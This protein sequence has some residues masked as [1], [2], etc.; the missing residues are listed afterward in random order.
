M[1]KPPDRPANQASRARPAAALRLL[2]RGPDGLADHELLALWLSLP[3]AARAAELL[4]RLGELDTQPAM[5]LLE[6][7]GLGPV[8]V[9]RLKAAAALLERWALS[10]LADQGPVLSCTTSVRAFLRGKLSR[11]TRE[12]FACLF[13]DSRHRLIRYEVLFM[14]TVD[15]AAVHPRE[16][17]RRALELN[18]AALI[19]AHNH[20]SGVPEPSASDLALTRDLGD[21][22]KKIDVRLLDHLVVGKGEEVSFAERGLLG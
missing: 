13:L 3:D 8:R 21:L 6:E 19:L 20:P 18:S 5:R 15:R 4:D 16:V 17:L 2:I 11:L 10:G 7:P 14:G 1:A 12:V 9:A 22:L